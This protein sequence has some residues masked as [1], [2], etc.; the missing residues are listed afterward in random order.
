ML[1]ADYD[2]AKAVAALRAEEGASILQNLVASS[3][4]VT[5][6]RARDAA[7]IRQMAEEERMHQQ[8]LDDLLDQLDA[9]P[10]PRRFRTHAGELNYHRIETA[11]PKLIADK[12]HL[13]RLYECAVPHVADDPY[14]AR[15]IADI[16]ARHRD[17]LRRLEE[18][19]HSPRS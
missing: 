12:K 16:T 9:T 8:W 10:G 5:Y 7:A 18:L 17:H 13:I 1:M 3:A 11:I 2:T 15:L 4:F 19:Q 14:A 6:A